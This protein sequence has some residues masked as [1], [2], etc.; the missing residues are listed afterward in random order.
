MRIT[1]ATSLIQPR[2]I[3]Q[4]E[5]LNWNFPDYLPGSSK[6]IHWYP[7]TFPAELPSTL[8]QALSRPDDLIF[9]PYGGVGTT[10]LEALRQKRKAWLVEC[11][12]VA[13]L[14]SYVSGGLILLKAINK[15]LPFILIDL[16]REVVDR[17]NHNQADQE[18]LVTDN[19]FL[20]ILDEHLTNIIK[21]NPSLFL[22]EYQEEPIWDELNHWIEE[23]TLN[24]LFQLFNAI[25]KS[26]LGQFGHLL[27]LIMIS[28]ILRPI[29]SQT[30]SWG[31][32]AD[33]VRP[34]EFEQKNV[35]QLCTKWL[36]RTK[37]ILEKTDVTQLSKEELKAPR[38]WISRHDWNQKHQPKLTPQH[39][40]N[41]IITSPPYA[42]AIDYVFA[43]R[44]SLYLLGY[45][46]EQIGQLSGS[47]IG[48]RR[49]RFISSSREKWADDLATSMEKQIAL[50]YDNSFIALVLPHKDANRDIG[51]ARIESLLLNNSWEKFFEVDRSI[52]QLRTRQ[53]WTS[54]RKETIQIYGH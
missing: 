20:A 23:Q 12:P 35:F 47:E 43:Q 31:H 53:S 41:V 36:N 10:A 33:N 4:L 29:S 39:A 40:A 37:A 22:E 27:G 2:L 26:S 21:P 7:G 6:S 50:L 18:K 3:R 5:A 24:D 28:A 38:Y 13:V 51:P 1:A 16:I 19:Q 49:K 44:L 32:I 17:S 52:R 11:N 45:S 14:A 8:I 15:N 54:I 48:A 9:D 34:K 46:I 42:G 30:K 25:K